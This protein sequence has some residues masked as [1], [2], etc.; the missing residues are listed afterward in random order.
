[1]EPLIDMEAA[2][3]LLSMD[4]KA[5]YEVCRSRSRMRQAVPIPRVRIGKRTLF[6]PSALHEWVLKLEKQAA[7]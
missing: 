4:K 1:M 7:L 6:R 3:R 5:L 2:A